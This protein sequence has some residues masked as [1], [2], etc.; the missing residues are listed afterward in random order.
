MKKILSLIL[1]LA[2]T[3]SLSTTALAADSTTSSISEN[4]AVELARWFIANDIY[5]NGNNGWSE[6]TVIDSV[7]TDSGFYGSS[8]IVNLSA[9]GKNNGYIVLGTTV[10]D[11]LIKEFS[12]SGKPLFVDLQPING[13]TAAYH[14]DNS[15]FSVDNTNENMPFLEKIRNTPS[16]FTS[17][18]NYGQITNPY[19]HVNDNYG[20]G[21]SLKTSKSISGFKLLDM[22][23]FEAE[24][25]CSLT[26]L[27]AIFN[28]HRS[29]GYS[30][31]PSDLNTL[32]GRI[33]TIATDNGY[34]TPSGTNPTQI[35][36]LAKDIWKYYG[37]SGTA[38]NDFFFNG[39]ESINNT[40]KGEV[41]GNR[42]GAISFTSGSYGNHTVT[43]YGYN[44][45][46]KSGSSDKLYLRVN[47]N[48]GTS[49]R[50]VDTTYIGS[51]G[52]TL[53]EI[54]GEIS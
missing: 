10:A 18:N 8:Y 32:F 25:H 34:Y 23:N 9:N 17:D 14:S 45:Y 20:T 53:F 7:T 13:G 52:H 1:V 54:C 15:V 12:Y 31:I 30:K 29:Q 49:A 19:Q 6:S 35:D 28:Y 11:V 3:F 33:K 42:P 47:D 2:M 51:L 46:K 24:N 21:W 5:E 48:W 27:T 22:A 43:Y 44:I 37:Y 26:T 50:Y 39:V 38:N 40:L 16:L 41:D 36:N 4:E